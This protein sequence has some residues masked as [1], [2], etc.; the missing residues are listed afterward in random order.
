MGRGQGRTGSSNQKEEEGLH[1][2]FVLGHA[3][4]ISFALEISQVYQPAQGSCMLGAVG[5]P[6]EKSSGVEIRAG[7]IYAQAL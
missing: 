1:Q 3:I 7:S 6:V 2:K 5:D 4:Y